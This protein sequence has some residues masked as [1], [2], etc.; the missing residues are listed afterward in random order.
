MIS[1]I[2]R[3]RMRRAKKS[4]WEMCQDVGTTLCKTCFLLCLDEVIS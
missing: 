4:L 3:C 2:P 1:L